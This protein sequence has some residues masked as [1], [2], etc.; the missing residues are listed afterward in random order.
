MAVHHMQPR[1]WRTSEITLLEEVVERSWNYIERVYS[2][3]ALTESELRF[4]SLAVPPP[5]LSGRRIRTATSL[6]RWPAGRDIHRADPCPILRRAGLDAVHPDERGSHGG[7]LEALDPP[8]LKFQAT[9]RIRRRDGAFRR[10]LIIGVPVLD[11]SGRSASGSA[12]AL[13]SRTSSRSRT[14]ASASFTRDARPAPKRSE[15]AG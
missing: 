13:I 7:L 10:M 6:A 11:V 1:I 3:L 8:G 5:S 15:P 9:V 4:R 12:P 2:N 14:S